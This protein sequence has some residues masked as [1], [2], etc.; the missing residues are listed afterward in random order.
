ML[1][2]GGGPL[3]NL[4]SPAPNKNYTPLTPA[5]RVASAPPAYQPSP[6]PAF[7][8]DFG[9][10]LADEIIQPVPFYLIDFSVE[11]SASDAQTGT[12]D[13]LPKVVDTGAR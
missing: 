10:A 6:S 12:S 9:N 8:G 4:S 7:S 3:A 11:T 5:P 13:P 2:A 1:T